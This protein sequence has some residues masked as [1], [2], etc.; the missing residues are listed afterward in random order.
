MRTRLLEHLEKVRYFQV[1]GEQGSIQEASRK[2]GIAQPALSKSLKILEDATGCLLLERT[3]QGTLLTKDGQALLDFSYKI[4]DLIK[5]FESEILPSAKGLSGSLSIGTHELYVPHIWP[6]I[7]DRSAQVAPNLNLKL[8]TDVKSL[9]L[10]SLL[11][12]QYLDIAIAIDSPI[13]S[14]ISKSLFYKDTYSFYCSNTFQENVKTVE[15]AFYLPN[16][17]V[18]KGE[19]LQSLLSQNGFD[20]DPAY[21][22]SSY[23]SILSLVLSG[24][25]IGILPDK[26]AKFYI[27]KKV[28]KKIKKFKIKQDPH[29]VFLYTRTSSQKNRNIDFFISKVL[30]ANKILL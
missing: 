13:P 14:S 27:K 16:S 30:Q 20:L 3:R 17:V 21:N 5:N 4:Q 6:S 7:L 8:T 25:G 24:V 15:K 23:A 2:I 1:I 18:K 22:V 26:P 19:T 11:K 9:N 29:S 28:I 10:M 12:K